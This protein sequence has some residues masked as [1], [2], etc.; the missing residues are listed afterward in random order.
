MNNR[1]Y[2][3]LEIALISINEYGMV[4]YNYFLFIRLENIDTKNGLPVYLNTLCR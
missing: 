3:R 2:Y 4:N 1:I